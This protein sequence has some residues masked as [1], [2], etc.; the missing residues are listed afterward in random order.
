MMQVVLNLLSNALKFTD[1]GGLI[2]ITSRLVQEFN[3]TYVQV[4]VQDNGVGI[5]KEN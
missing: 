2:T 4:S 3:Q 1:E 5:S